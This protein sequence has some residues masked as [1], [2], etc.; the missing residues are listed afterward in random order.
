MIFAVFFLLLGGA[1]VPARG[2]TPNW[3]NGP[4]KSD[5]IECNR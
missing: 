4:N 2:M 3:G 5:K 1:G